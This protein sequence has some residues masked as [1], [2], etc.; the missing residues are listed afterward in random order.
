MPRGALHTLLHSESADGFR[1][2]PRGQRLRPPPPRGHASNTAASETRSSSPI[3]TR[4]RARTVP[5]ACLV[6]VSRSST[7]SLAARGCGSCTAASSPRFANTRLGRASPGVR[8]AAARALRAQTRWRRSQ[9]S[10]PAS[11]R[12]TAWPISQPR[13]CCKKTRRS[14]SCTATRRAAMSFT[15]PYALLPYTRK[16]LR[17]QLIPPHALAFLARIGARA[18]RPAAQPSSGSLHRFL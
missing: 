8:Q 12:V 14:C 3:C 10:P 16:A 1:F 18:A 11:V 7:G 6:R 17:A 4:L 13:S 2:E 15:L 5:E 9:S